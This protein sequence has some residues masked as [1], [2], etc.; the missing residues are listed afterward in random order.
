MCPSLVS[1][2]GVG[3]VY[4]LLRPLAM[5]VHVCFSVEITDIYCLV[6]IVL[7]ITKH[8]IAFEQILF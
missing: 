1:F 6:L 2:C 3:C 5:Y 4:T 8:C 7:L